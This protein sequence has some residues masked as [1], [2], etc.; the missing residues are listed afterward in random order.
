MAHGALYANLGQIEGRTPTHA[1]GSSASPKLSHESYTL[2]QQE[3]MSILL[4][5]HSPWG[6]PTTCCIVL[7]VADFCTNLSFQVWMMLI[8]DRGRREAT[9]YY[10]LDCSPD[11]MW[12]L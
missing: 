1:L 11:S 12:S 4:L 7:W 9:D 8:N 10:W 3:S 6:F 2:L 5:S